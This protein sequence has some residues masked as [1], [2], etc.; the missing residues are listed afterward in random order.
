MISE[1]SK[2]IVSQVRSALNITSE[3]DDIALYK[4]LNN[5]YLSSHPDKFSNKENKKIAE[6]RF[7]NLGNLREKLKNYLEQQRVKGQLITSDYSHDMTEVDTINSLT[8]KDLKI[9]Q[10]QEKISQLELNLEITNDDLKQKEKQITDYLIQSTET[11]KEKLTDIYKPKNKGNVLGIGSAIVSLS[12]F[13]P[14]VQK[15]VTDIGIGGFLGSC[16]IICVSIIW[17]IQIARNNICNSCIQSIIDKILYGDDLVK[18]FDV[19]YPIDKYS[20]PYFKEKAVVDYIERCMNIPKYRLLFRGNYNSIRRQIVEYIL[21][22]LSRKK[23]IV[24]VKSNGMQKVF[25][26]ENEDLY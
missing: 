17:L 13:I 21:L 26:V 11:T 25:L 6:E 9:I 8:E 5:E 23:I 19:T 14:Q 2:E 22:E 10:L 18:A 7:K 12:L 24:K 16:I 4:K 20:K 3:L 15:I 1:I